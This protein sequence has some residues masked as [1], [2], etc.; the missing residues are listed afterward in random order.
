MISA[1]TRRANAAVAGLGKYE[2][3]RN[4]RARPQRTPRS[5][6]GRPNCVRVTGS[7]PTPVSAVAPAREN[8]DRSTRVTGC[9]GGVARRPNRADRDVDD[10]GVLEPTAH[11]VMVEAEPAIVVLFAKELELVRVEVVIAG[12]PR[13][14]RM[15]TSSRLASAVEA[16]WSRYMF[17]SA[18][19]D[20]AGLERRRGFR[21]SYA[22]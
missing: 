18:L 19:I 1:T 4:L 16:T 22:G 6:S 17:A 14:R 7:A 3:A 11:A 21:C 9:Q 10:A 12:A 20:G 13:G 2:V 8:A 5:P 15:R